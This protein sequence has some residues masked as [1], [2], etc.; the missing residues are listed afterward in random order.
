MR[1][2]CSLYRRYLSKHS[3]RFQPDTRDRIRPAQGWDGRQDSR[4]AAWWESNNWQLAQLLGDGRNPN[5]L[6]LIYAKS[7]LVENQ[8][9]WERWGISLEL[10]VRAWSMKRAE[11]A[12]SKATI[13]D[14]VCCCEFTSVGSMQG[15]PDQA[16]TCPGLSEVC[17]WPS[18]R[19]RG[20]VGEDLV[21][22]WDQNRFFF[23]ASCCSVCKPTELQTM[24]TVIVKKGFWQVSWL[25]W[26]LVWPSAPITHL[27][28]GCL[29]V[30]RWC[31]AFLRFF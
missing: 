17:Q 6:E 1:K 29:C 25:E 16:S 27:L 31:A 26:H 19:S 3:I 28:Q 23:L 14:T 30:Q 24:A 13:S 18:R 21:V 2:N 12:V 7:H 9:S 15:P 10:H 22:R 8:W 11:T 20:G 4:Q 5:N